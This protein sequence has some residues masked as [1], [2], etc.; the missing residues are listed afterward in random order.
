MAI[1]TIE[2]NDVVY[3]YIFERTSTSK[4]QTTSSTL[5]IN[6]CCYGVS[7]KTLEQCLPNIHDEQSNKNPEHVR[8]K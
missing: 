2:I 7:V 1:H 6:Q 5:L 4:A 8:L 3:S